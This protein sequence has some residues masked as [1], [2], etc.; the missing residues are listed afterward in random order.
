MFLMINSLIIGLI[1]VILIFITGCDSNNIFKKPVVAPVYLDPAQAEDIYIEELAEQFHF[2]ELTKDPDFLIKAISKLF[3]TDSLIIVADNS[4]KTVFIFDRSGNPVTK[5]YRQGSG[6]GEYPQMVDLWFEKETSYLQI[7]DTKRPKIYTYSL[8]GT[9]IEE[10]AFEQTVPVGFRLARTDYFYVVDR[11]SM[12]GDNKRLAIYNENLKLTG[13]Y[14]NIPSG[15]IDIHYSTQKFFDVLNDTL[16]YMPIFSDTI[17]TIHKNGPQ[18][19]YSINVPNK[20]KIPTDFLSGKRFGSIMNLS[21]SV[22]REWVYDASHINLTDNYLNF[23]Y[24]YNSKHINVF[25]SKKSNIVKQLNILKSR[26]NMDMML[27]PN[28]LENSDGFFISTVHPTQF[29]NLP[30]PR[31]KGWSEDTNA[32]LLF[33]KLKDF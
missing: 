22:N 13:T 33:M 11:L 3:V 18:A 28:I 26:S 25:S 8:D 27:I 19:R 7:L 20:N 23:R 21:A 16:Y 17:Y 32:V 6:P 24:R 4:Q 12:Q 1:S 10:R 2:V 5:I 14:I 31:A 29:N 15:I 30:D 9:F